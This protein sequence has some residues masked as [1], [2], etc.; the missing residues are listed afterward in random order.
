MK[1]KHGFPFVSVTFTINRFSHI[2]SIKKN[3]VSFFNPNVDHPSLHQSRKKNY[4]FIKDQNLVDKK[5]IPAFSQNS[6]EFSAV[7]V[8][9]LTGSK[10]SPN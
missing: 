1:I 10:Y 4:L 6:L 9:Q 3:T 8:N 2:F 5:S 7:V